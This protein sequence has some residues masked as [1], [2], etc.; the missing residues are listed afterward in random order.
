M[1]SERA[2]LE[3]QL[4]GLERA[5]DDLVA[6]TDLEP[7]DDEHDPDG[8]TAYERAQVS[9]LAAITRAR[10]DAL[11]RALAAV[12]DD[13]YGTCELCGQPIGLERLQAV[14]GTTRCVTCAQR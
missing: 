13:G 14:A 2:R 10:M 7:P 5:F 6:A 8:T 4:A 3:G 9:S 12:D 11:D 1:Q